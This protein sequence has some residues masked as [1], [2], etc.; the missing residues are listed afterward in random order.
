M[1]IADLK[2]LHKLHNDINDMLFLLERMNIEKCEKLCSLYDIKN[3]L[4]I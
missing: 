3:M 4:Y 1:K 2:Q